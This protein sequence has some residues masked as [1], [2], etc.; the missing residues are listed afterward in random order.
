VRHGQSGQSLVEALVAAAVLGVGVVTA[1]TALDT[2]VAGAKEATGQ[3][4]ATCAVRAEA[5]ILEAAQWDA[6]ASYPSTI[7]NVSVTPLPSTDPQVLQV[8]AT[9]PFSG[10]TTTA[11]VLKASALS[12]GAPPPPAGIPISPGAWCGYVTRAAP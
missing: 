12:G 9:D 5:G 1:L 4:W 6:S 10:A 8:T 3:A 7:S 11:I 2:M